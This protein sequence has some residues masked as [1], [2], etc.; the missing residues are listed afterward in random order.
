MAA[1]TTRV[2]DIPTTATTAAA[3]DYVL[4]DGATNGT[5]KGLASNLITATAAAVAGLVY[6]AKTHG[7]K[8][9]GI[10]DD[11][12]AINAVIALACAGNG[13]TIWFPTG[14][15]L[16]LGQLV[17][18]T[19]A[20]DSGLG[21]YSQKPIRITG[22]GSMSGT[23]SFQPAAAGGSILDMRYAGGTGRFVTLGSGNLELD[24]IS[25]ADLS[26][27]Q[28]S[29]STPFFF[30]TNT[31]VNIHDVSFIGAQDQSAFPNLVQ[32]AIILGGVGPDW[33]TDATS[34]FGGYGSCVH[35]CF[36]NWVR[37][38]IVFGGHCNA[39]QVTDNNVWANC[40][41]ATAGDAAFILG[42][43]S[44]DAS[45]NVISGNLIEGTYAYHFKCV[46][47]NGNLFTGNLSFDNFPLT[48]LYRFESGCRENMVVLAWMT[49][50]IPVLSE[51]TSSNKTVVISSR[52]NTRSSFPNGISTILPIGVGVE[53]GSAFA[54]T[55]WGATTWSTSTTDPLDTT[56]ARISLWEGVKPTFTLDNGTTRRFGDL[57]IGLLYSAIPVVWK[58]ENYQISLTDDH[59]K[60]FT[61]TGAG[62]FTYSLPTAPIVGTHF[63]FLVD[64]ASQLTVSA[65]AG[66][67]IRIGE[68]ASASGGTA[69][70]S[71]TGSCLHLVYVRD[72]VW[73]ADRQPLGT[74]TLT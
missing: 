10:T 6:N 30:T 14:T 25:I 51:A 66:V 62:A 21:N 34:A 56:I 15:Y 61:N 22:N 46:N 11:T 48:A 57:R 13:G 43:S 53:E 42:N 26:G 2:K 45:G 65:P 16:I 33:T 20:I 32:D 70:N 28:S 73:M 19:D 52:M 36:F 74:W 67:T 23:F 24:H 1:E 68:S 39:I 7:A 50:N 35:H 54:T 38:V 5:R 64:A 29:S 41:S 3:D 44:A 12:A 60:I 55:K 58:G 27:S 59:G 63:S 4:L 31:T 8:G 71:A 72:G 37:H 17:I 40:G 49:L 18:P 47:S 69:S 9:D